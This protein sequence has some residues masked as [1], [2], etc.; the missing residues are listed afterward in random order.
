MFA[1]LL[2]LAQGTCAG[3]TQGQGGTLRHF[4]LMALADSI[5]LNA[6]S[7]GGKVFPAPLSKNSQGSSVSVSHFKEAAPVDAQQ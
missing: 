6:T 5:Q 3:L 2:R 1:T 4:I 7:E